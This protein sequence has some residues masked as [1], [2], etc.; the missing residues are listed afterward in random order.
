[1]KPLSN[2]QLQ[3]LFINMEGLVFRVASILAQHQ[4]ATKPALQDVF[5]SWNQ[6]VKDIMKE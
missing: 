5:D 6:I 4:P 2:V 1:M 3:D